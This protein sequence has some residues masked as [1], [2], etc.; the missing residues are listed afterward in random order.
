MITNTNPE[1]INLSVERFLW[2]VGKKMLHED[3]NEPLGN[4]AIADKKRRNVEPCSPNRRPRTDS[5]ITVHELIFSCAITRYDGYFEDSYYHHKV[6]L[7]PDSVVFPGRKMSIYIYGEQPELW[8]AL[9]VNQLV[10]T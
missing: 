5:L 1:C 4:R 3:I 7:A 2:M 9:Q 10:N 8:P 6:S